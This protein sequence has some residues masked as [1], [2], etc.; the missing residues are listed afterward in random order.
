MTVPGREPA[1]PVTIALARDHEIVHR[2]LT[3]MLEPFAQLA[4]V[5]D[6]G[7]RADLTLVDPDVDPESELLARALSDPRCGRV[8]LFGWRLD[9]PLVHQALSRGAGGYVAKSLSAGQLVEALRDIRDGSV[10]VSETDGTTWQDFQVELARTGLTPREADV[11]ALVTSGHSNVEI[12]GELYVSIN[13][14]K[15]YIRSAYRKIGV[16]TRARA[17]LWGIQH[18]MHPAV[19][20]LHPGG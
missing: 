11:I 3:R 20:P 6:H 5:V 18:G 19:V 9:A 17:V 12:A 10:V 7:H 15:S 8:V 4:Q 1:G 16:T 14:V 2:G 13:S